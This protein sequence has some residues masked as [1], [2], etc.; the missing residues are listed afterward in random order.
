MSK[1]L[2]VVAGAGGVIG[3]YI[4][5]HLPDETGGDVVGLSRR[6]LRFPTSARWLQVD[7]LDVADCRQKLATLSGATHLFYAAYQE[8]GNLLADLVAPNESML[9]NVVE[10]LEDAAP[11]LQRVVLYTGGKAY[12]SHLG[13][14]RTPARESDPRHMPPN[15][16]YNQEDYLA[17]R[18]AGKR[19]S[20]T[21]LR[22]TN[23]CGLATGNPMNISTVIAVYAAISK[24]LGLPLRF[25][26]KEVTYEKLS[27]FTDSGHLAR[28]S[29]WAAQSE[30]CANQVL[31]LHNGDHVRWKYL[32]PA[33]AEFFE[34]KLAEPQRIPLHAFMADKA[35]LWE[36][37]VRKYGLQP[38][39]FA[40]VAAW[41][42]GD[43]MFNT[44]EWDL[45]TSM[46]KIRQLGF[47]PV[48]DT[49]AMYLRLFRE[50]RAA[51][52]I[53]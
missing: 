8:R 11:D 44:F 20:W 2:A 42:F 52:L 5:T 18:Q 4:A 26:G 15:F 40:E 46:T 36:S 45:M 16:Y 21:V 1:P 27:Q 39:P 33:F 14:Y 50:F 49:E 10:A 23:I 32:W 31:N 13:P 22:P 38:L 30:A 34:M 17:E 47:H 41:A 35:P 7:L 24:E 3:R 51:R 29:R 6:P 43:F 37:M 12:G 25:P 53:P 19:W 28:G 48:V 9:R